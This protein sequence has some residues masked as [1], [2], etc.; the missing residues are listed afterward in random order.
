MANNDGNNT[1][2]QPEPQEPES[3]VLSATLS[4]DAVFELLASNQRRDM[5]HVL[6]DDPEKTATVTEL[7]THLMDQEAQRTG[8]RPG[9][10]QLEMTVH[11]IHLP[12]LTDAGI[13]EYDARSQELRYW[14]DKRLEAL[15]DYISEWDLA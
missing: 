7:I 13:V 14:P 9:R 2:D 11:H 4:V 1:A 3:D 6:R 15:L 10:D 12:K 8:T 5:L